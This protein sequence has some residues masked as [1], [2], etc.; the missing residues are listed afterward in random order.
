MM[1]IGLMIYLGFSVIKDTLPFLRSQLT[2]S[3]SSTALPSS[4]TRLHLLVDKLME[5]I[6]DLVAT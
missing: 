3:A 1:R 4:I 5:D 2:I 6:G